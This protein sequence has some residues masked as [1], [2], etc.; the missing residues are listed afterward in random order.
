M[1]EVIEVFYQED[2]KIEIDFGGLVIIEGAQGPPGV[3]G[4]AGPIGPQ[5]PKGDIGETG[6]QGSKGDPGDTGPQ[7]PKGDSGD[8]GPQGP[9]GDPGE[10]G[11]QGPK[12][13]TGDTG[14]QGIQG[15]IGPAGPITD[16]IK[17]LIPLFI[18]L[19]HLQMFGDPENPDTGQIS[20]GTFSP[21]YNVYYPFTS[22][23]NNSYG[24]QLDLNI[25]AVR[26][27]FVKIAFIIDND[28]YIEIETQGSRD[29]RVYSI[30]NG[31]S[32][33]LISHRFNGMVGGAIINPLLIYYQGRD[34]YIK[35]RMASN[36]TSNNDLAIDLG[37]HFDIRNLTAIA[38]KT[39]NIDPVGNSLTKIKHVVLQSAFITN[40]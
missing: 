12:G 17:A 1:S 26:V 9:K 34:L 38:F 16:E 13:D 37:S 21:D 36:G 35:L 40:I 19:E 8:T 20:S 18:N 29:C 32:T 39:E 5:G 31:I 14:P 7:G 33:Q 6:P 23:G 4:A 24:I 30:V 15:P 10:T 3:P 25:Y 2:G 22:N 27:A 28:N 11:P